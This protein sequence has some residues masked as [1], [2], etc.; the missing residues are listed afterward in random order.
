MNPVAVHQLRPSEIGN[1]DFF[2]GFKH[3]RAIHVIAS[4]SALSN[5]HT[6]SQTVGNQ[7][8][9]LRY[10]RHI[11]DIGVGKALE[12]G[13]KPFDGIHE[14]RG[15]HSIVHPIEMLY[16]N[17]VDAFHIVGNQ[18]FGKKLI[19]GSINFSNLFLTLFGIS[20]RRI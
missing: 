6:H 17:A 10:H 8:V 12:I 7:S 13:I 4:E 19:Y 15:R 11:N 2:V 3:F 14:E 20:C 16:H 9:V 18:A 1:R 5:H